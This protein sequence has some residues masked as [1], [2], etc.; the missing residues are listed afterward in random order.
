MSHNGVM[1]TILLSDAALAVANT[2]AVV[3]LL[4]RF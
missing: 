4:V 3:V 1:L 2:V